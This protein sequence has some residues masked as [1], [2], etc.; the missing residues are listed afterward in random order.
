MTVL[1]M[2]MAV[3]SAVGTRARAAETCPITVTITKVA[4]IE[5]CDE[6]GIEAVGESTPDFYA[7]VFINGEKQ[8]AGSDVDDPSTEVID[9][10][11]MTSRR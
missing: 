11:A 3:T 1:A 2:V 4:C 7:K 6:E 8:P 10:D 5:D 9:D